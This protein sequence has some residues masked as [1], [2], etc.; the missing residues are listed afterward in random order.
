MLLYHNFTILQFHHI[1]NNIY[2]DEAHGH[3]W[4]NLLMLF[5]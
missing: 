2:D 1:P 3:G 4:N 5:Y